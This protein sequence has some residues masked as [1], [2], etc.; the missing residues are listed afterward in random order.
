MDK[1]YD[2][3]ERL[4]RESGKTAD[5]I[6]KAGLP[7]LKKMRPLVPNSGYKIDPCAFL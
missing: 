4:M 3:A 1:I 7:F 6:L 5:R 2:A